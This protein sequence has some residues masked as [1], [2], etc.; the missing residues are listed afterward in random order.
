MGEKGGK[1]AADALFAELQVY[2][3]ELTGVPNNM[4]ILVRA[5]ANI[6]GLGRTLV[7]DGRLHDINHLRAFATGFSNRQVFFDFVDVGSGKERADYK[8]QGKM[9]Q[10][11]FVVPQ[12]LFS[13]F[14][15]S[16]HTLTLYCHHRE[17]QIFRGQ[18]SVQ[19]SSG[20]LRARHRL[21]PVP[22]TVCW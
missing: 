8:I 21:C 4:D 9:Y 16:V 6:S 14:A 15:S 12:I 19:T 2:M 18:S 10:F 20:R 7:R 3:R 17:H 13:S 11:C 22:G 1:D 5:F